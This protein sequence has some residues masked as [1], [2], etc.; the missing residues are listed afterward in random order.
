MS[1]KGTLLF[2]S[3]FGPPLIQTGSVLELV[4]TF[5]VELLENLI[6]FL[7]SAWSFFDSAILKE[8]SR[9]LAIA[10]F[11]SCALVANS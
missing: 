4:I 9:R 8:L 7:N 1:L 10:T 2:S 6:L 5:L 11:I 3:E